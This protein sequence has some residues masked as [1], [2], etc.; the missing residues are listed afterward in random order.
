[1]SPR[2]FGSESRIILAMVGKAFMGPVPLTSCLLVGAIAL[3]ACAGANPAP[4]KPGGAPP[5]AIVAAESQ[6]GTTVIAE[7]PGDRTLRAGDRVRCRWK[8]GNTEY[9]GHIAEVRGDQLFIKYDDGDEEL[10][11]PA[12]CRKDGGS[13]YSLA[14]FPVGARVRC[15]WKGR[16]TEYPGTVAAIESNQ[17]LIKY[18]DGDEEHTVPSL[19]RPA[20]SAATVGGGTVFDIASSSNPGGGKPYGGQVALS[21]T[22]EVFQLRWS[23]DNTPPYTGVGIEEGNVLGVGWGVGSNQGIVVYRIQGG[24]LRGRWASSATRGHVGTEDLQGP[25]GLNGTYKIVASQSPVGGK[26][27]TGTVTIQPTG[28]T[29]SLRWQLANESYAGVGIKRG[30]VLFV[31]WGAGKGSGV[32]VYTRRGDDLDGVWASPGGTQLGTEVLERYR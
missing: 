5:A 9:A 17:L 10:T 30:N 20:D 1:M 25:P 15:Q 13:G 19:C 28:D 26:S 29:Y 23:I 22:G 6:P 11:T 21:K 12:L 18:D 8:G 24:T 2:T 31:G 7:A 4:G 16:P 3:S 32:V 14:D 27:Y